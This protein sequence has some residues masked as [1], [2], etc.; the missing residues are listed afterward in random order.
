MGVALMGMDINT[1]SAYLQITVNIENHG[2]YV[3]N[4]STYICYSYRYSN[5]IG[6]ITHA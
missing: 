3:E 6:D 1:T 2:Q 5:Y 4:L